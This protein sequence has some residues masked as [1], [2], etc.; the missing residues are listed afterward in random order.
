LAAAQT[1]TFTSSDDWVPYS[2]SQD[3]KGGILVQIAKAAFRASGHEIDVALLPWARAVREAQLG[4]RT[5]VIGDWYSKER[6]KDFLYSDPIMENDIV[7]F[8]FSDRGVSYRKLEDLKAYKIGA[9][10]DNAFIEK[11]IKAGLTIDY[12]TDFKLNLKKLIGGRI[13]LLADEKLSTLRLLKESY[14]SYADRIVTLQPPIEVN[15]LYLLVSKKTDRASAI[16]TEFNEGLKV[17]LSDG[18]MKKILDAY[19]YQ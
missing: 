16:V 15:Y 9:V 4:L 1:Y 7:F 11:L 8:A 14:P 17:I 5:G 18:T 2:S 12:A 19:G 6:E 10:R 3:P 13:D